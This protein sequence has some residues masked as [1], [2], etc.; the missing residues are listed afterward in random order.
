MAI[1]MLH[2]YPQFL[3]LSS[4][5][6]PF[7]LS[8]FPLSAMPAL[9]SKALAPWAG[10]VMAD[11]QDRVR[12]IPCPRAQPSI[13]PTPLPHLPLSTLWPLRVFT[14]LIGGSWG[15]RVH[16]TVFSLAFFFV[17]DWN[18]I[19]RGREL[20]PSASWEP[21]HRVFSPW[22]FLSPHRTPYAI[23]T[24]QKG[25]GAAITFLRW[26][27]SEPSFFSVIEQT[28]PQGRGQ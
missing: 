20:S 5:F 2:N 26:P 21:A 17:L 10:A 15:G 18:P 14:E 25:T 12:G 8:F 4:L 7:S 13:S 11:A 16:S 24:Q 19:P 3:A 23:K 1:R 27:N 6:T 9:I 22:N 28:P